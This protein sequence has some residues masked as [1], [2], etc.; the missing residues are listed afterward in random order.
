VSCRDAFYGVELAVVVTYSAIEMSHKRSLA[1][2]KA[3]RTS[4]QTRAVTYKVNENDDIYDEV[5]NDGFRKHQQERLREDDFVVDDNGEGYMDT[6]ADYWETGAHNYY[7][8]DN[9]NEIRP[10]KK[11]KSQKAA[12][13]AKPDGNVDVLFKRVSAATTKQKVGE[14]GKRS[15]DLL[16]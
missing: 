6:G 4:G 15:Q 11:A 1:E 5:D 13:P 10:Q 9:D 3:L 14:N 7:S 8:D 2:L 16:I 12:K